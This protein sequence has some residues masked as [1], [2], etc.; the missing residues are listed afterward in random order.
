VNV[1]RDWK[2]FLDRDL[3]KQLGLALRAVG[4]DATN[5]IYR[6]PTADAES[7]SDRLWI[8]EATE[9]G[10]VIL[11]R[12]GSIRRR[13]AELAVVI[14]VGARCFVFETGNA[15][16]LDNLRALMVALPRMVEVVRDEDR[17]YMYGI[18]PDGTLIRRYPPR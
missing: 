3:G 16:A 18:R 5:H 9:R 15:S 13:E 11:T 6:Y 17:P 10:E 14:E 1:L 8:R 2:V 4:V 12:D 7:V